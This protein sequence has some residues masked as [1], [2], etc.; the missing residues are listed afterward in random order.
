M[1]LEVPRTMAA[2]T[3]IQV[4]E[5][6]LRFP[7]SEK[8]WPFNFL[9]PVHRTIS[10]GGE[11]VSVS[12][13]SWR[14]WLLRDVVRLWP[15]RNAGEEGRGESMEGE[16][17]RDWNRLSNGL[18]DGVGLPRPGLEA[19]EGRTLLPGELSTEP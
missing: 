7:A 2:E 3:A 9:S 14:N 18:N 1:P 12:P 4:G 10:H 8:A 6:K 16:A 17:M 15:P 13:G 19:I 11:G 5:P